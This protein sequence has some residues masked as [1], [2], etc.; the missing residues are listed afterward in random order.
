MGTIPASFLPPRES[1]PTRI[2]ALPEHRDYPRRLN[3]TEELLDRHVESGR[4]DRVAILYEDQRITYRQ[5]HAAVVRLASAL[6]ALGLEADDRVLLRAPSIPP[7]L[8]ANFAVLR[9]GGIVVPTSPLFSRAELVHIA[10]NTEAVALVVA[11]PLLEEV[12]KARPELR[13]LR[14]VIVIGGDPGELR[15]RGYVPYGELLARGADRCEPVRRDREAVSVLLYTSGTTGLPKGTVHVVEE[16]LTVP[17]GFGKHGWR[18][19][20]DDVIGGPAP[21]SLAAGYSTQAVIPFRFG[22]A[23][24]LLPR[25]TPEGMFDQ[26]Q[27]HRI[28]IVSILPTAYRKMMQV[29]DAA[30]RYDLGSVRTCTGGGESLGAETYARWKE[31]FGLEIYEGLGTTELMYVFASSAVTRRVKPGAI[32]PAVPGYEL[33]VVTEDGAPAPPG[34][35]GLLLVRGP[36]GTLYWRDPDRQQAA[37]RDGW[38]RAGDF[39]SMDEDG[40]VWFMAREDDLIK[41]SGYRIGPE[42][43]ED[44]L[45]RHPAVADVGVIGVPDPVRGQSTRAYVVLHAGRA[46]SNALA[47]ELIEFCRDHIAVYKLPREI[48]FVAQLP[49]APGPAG[50]GTGKLLRRILRERLA[51]PGPP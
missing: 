37:V 38:S 8:V 33:R 26:I 34:E 9:I 12:E 30:R 50:P 28:T 35:V 19:E 16:A 27:K 5:L 46:P 44:A 21:L 18:V 25:F 43:V 10:E 1:W 3:S 36:T 6:Q 31:M 51:P 49:R 11:A 4:A 17:D 48:E 14:H 15:A 23:A 2:H 24:S 45:A 40:Y 47:G 29:P 41:S 22:A 20:P 13:R 39:V 7:A 42:E 32:G